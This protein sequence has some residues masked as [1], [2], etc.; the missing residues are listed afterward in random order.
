MGAHNA[1]LNLK[2]PSHHYQQKTT[3]N[4]AEEVK[5]ND[6]TDGPWRQLHT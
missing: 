1:N 6:E 2:N 5:H 4:Q 3:K